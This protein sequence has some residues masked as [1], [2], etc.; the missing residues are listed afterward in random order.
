MKLT[1]LELLNF[2]G[3]K[4][5]TINLNGDVVIRGD[6]ATGK[7]TDQSVA[8]VDSVVLI[9]GPE[10]GISP[11]ELDAFTTAGAHPVRLGPEVLRTASA[12]MVALAALGAVTDR[13]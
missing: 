8:Q 10:G 1:K 13:W 6:N 9:I 7:T 5:F 12:G 4:S 3:L 11:A 2:K